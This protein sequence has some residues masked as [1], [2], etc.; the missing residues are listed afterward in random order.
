MSGSVQET[1]RLA[2]AKYSEYEKRIECTK[3]V[4]TVVTYLITAIAITILLTLTTLY[5]VPMLYQDMAFAVNIAISGLVI[6]NLSPLI[7]QYFNEKIDSQYL[8]FLQKEEKE[9]K[10]K[11]KQT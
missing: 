1:A 11:L 3:K 4:V 10:I 8:Q 9:L 5:F 7:V 6:K 2:Q